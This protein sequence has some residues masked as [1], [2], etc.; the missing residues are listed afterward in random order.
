[1]IKLI[2]ES[3]V[4]KLFPFLRNMKIKICQFQMN[5]I[6]EKTLLKPILISVQKNGTITNRIQIRRI[7]VGRKIHKNSLFRFQRQFNSWNHITIGRNNNRH[8]TFLLIGIR[9]DLGGNTDIR[10]LFLVCANLISTIPTCHLL[11]Q[12]FP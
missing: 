8:I 4:L 3:F 9:D 12:V 11:S 5:N 2:N 7:M 6:R 10:F 1:M